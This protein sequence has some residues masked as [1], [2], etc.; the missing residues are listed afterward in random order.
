MS[1]RFLLGRTFLVTLLIFALGLLETV[2]MTAAL[3]LRPSGGPLLLTE[4][5]PS[6]AVVRWRQVLGSGTAPLLSRTIELT[7]AHPWLGIDFYLTL[8]TTH[9]A[10]GSLS[11][12]HEIQ[13]RPEDFAEAAF[14]VLRINGVPLMGGQFQSTEWK[15][16]DGSMTVHLHAEVN[17]G[18]EFNAMLWTPPAEDPDL[19]QEHHRLPS[20]LSNELSVKLVHGRLLSMS[21]VPT[22][23]DSQQVRLVAEAG[24]SLPS[25]VVLMTRTPKRDGELQ[26]FDRSRSPRDLLRW[27]DAVAQVVP[28]LST[29]L[30]SIL[31]ALPLL[32]FLY[33]LGAKTQPPSSLRR[34]SRS[35]EAAITFFLV[36][37]LATG[38]NKLVNRIA[39]LHETVSSMW[40]WLDDLL[41]VRLGAHVDI[42]ILEAGTAALV[43]IL[44]PALFFLRVEENAPKSWARPRRLAPWFAVLICAVGL[45]LAYDVYDLLVKEA[46][47]LLIASLTFLFLFAIS[48]LLSRWLGPSRKG[49]A[50]AA[51]LM[52]LFIVVSTIQW[53]FSVDPWFALLG[54]ALAGGFLAFSMLMLVLRTAGVTESTL[55]KRSRHCRPL[56]FLLCTLLALPM[57]ASFVTELGYQLFN[58]VPLLWVGALLWYLWRAGKD[59][60]QVGDTGRVLGVLATSSLLFDPL[61]QWCFIPI[62]FLLGWATLHFLVVRRADRWRALASL[63]PGD[64]DT[65]ATQLD[66]LLDL[67]TAESAYNGLREQL[68]KKL[69]SAE[70]GFDA[71]DQ[72]LTEER[73]KLQALRREAMVGEL[74]I[75]DFALAFGPQRTATDNA[76]HGLR[77]GLAFAS[78]WILIGLRNLLVSTDLDRAYPLWQMLSEFITL[79]AKWGVIGSFFGYFYPYLPGK[80]GLTKGFYLFLVIVLPALPLASIQFTS[81]HE[82]RALAFWS[83]QAFIECMLLGLIAFDYATLRHSGYGDWRLLFQVHDL[84]SLGISVSSIV[85]AIGGTV[86]ALISG[87]AVTLVTAALRIFLPEL[88]SLPL[89]EKPPGP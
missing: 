40:Q 52:A 54:A 86:T 28:L 16:V 55:A 17:M 30:T 22:A 13:R 42:F 23:A 14:G 1:I 37:A 65:R 29:L 35:V 83:T 26:S 48:Y 31:R 71:Y 8:P 50:L 18:K 60:L 53:G 56:L 82:W 74:S 62:T 77:Y 88:P 38:L 46:I 6:E 15:V 70:L 41:K 11:A 68:R 76:L 3:Y 25:R 51:L 12:S 89:D 44:T 24:E 59:S 78:P 72:R 27:V 67:N 63:Q 34:L 47:A 39:W 80:S 75:R 79:I 49:D 73:N 64:V 33:F 20:S 5:H 2:L 69:V 66:K 36:L 7:V 19:G 45:L 4:L 10:A 84:S 87:N 43:G 61:A 9:P 57:G 32:L 21:P 85:V 58:L 81:Q